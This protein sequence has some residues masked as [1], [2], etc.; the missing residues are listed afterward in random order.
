[1]NN[2]RISLAAMCAL[3]LM[4]GCGAIGDVLGTGS[5]STTPNGQSTQISG[6]V[7]NVDTNAH[8][9]DISGNNNYTNT[10]YYD[11]RTQFTYQNQNVN[12]SSIR[13]GDQVNIT[14]YNNGNGQYTADTV[15]IVG[16]G[17]A[18]NYPGTNPSTTNGT[19][20]IQG[21]VNN[22]DTSAMRIDVTS[23][24]VTGLRTN[25]NQGNYSIY[26]DTRTPVLYQGQSYSPSALERG[27]QIDVQAFDNGG[28]RYMA[29]QITVTRNVRQ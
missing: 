23:A 9:L 2:L 26:Y 7:N 6:V 8:R 13:R 17:M 4:A 25:G 14:A 20:Q 22:V 5:P 10:V 15:Y 28:G 16:S 19:F 24:Y 21:T 1:M 11:S 18:S 27:D 29:N 3:I 12:P